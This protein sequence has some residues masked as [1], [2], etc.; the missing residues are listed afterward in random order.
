MCQK[1][2]GI[3][4]LAEAALT[5]EWCSTCKKRNIFDEL[6]RFEAKEMKKKE[7]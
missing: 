2:E 7:Y 4:I 3:K 6:L 1:Y 5:F